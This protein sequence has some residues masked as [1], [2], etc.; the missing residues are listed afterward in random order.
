MT[1]IEKIE[2][3]ISQLPPKELAEFRDWFEKRDSV[4]WD[5]QFE[6][7]AKSNKL[8][9]LSKQA[10]KDFKNGHYKKI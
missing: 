9:D 3:E 1:R 8:D 2:S 10:I 7:D 4:L 6:A 5:K